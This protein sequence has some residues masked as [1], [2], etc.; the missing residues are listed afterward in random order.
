MAKV[1]ALHRPAQ[2]KI[3]ASLLPLKGLR[4]VP[5]ENQLLKMFKLLLRCLK[6]QLKSKSSKLKN[7]SPQALRTLKIKQTK[8]RL[9]RIDSS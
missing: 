8:K 9:M 6:R 5:M 7:Q 4:L 3:R 1:R 2:F